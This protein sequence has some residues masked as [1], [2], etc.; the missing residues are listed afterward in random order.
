MEFVIIYI[1]TIISTTVI[2]LENVNKLKKIRISLLSCLVL[3]SPKKEIHICFLI[4]R[5]F[6][7]LL[8]VICFVVAM[9]NY[10]INPPKLQIMYGFVMIGVIVPITILIDV[11]YRNK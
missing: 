9:G 1:Y 5:I 4:I 11:I 10:R 7:Q 8:T 3:L 2:G 6:T